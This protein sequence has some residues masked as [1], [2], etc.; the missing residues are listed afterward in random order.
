MLY[1]F[2]MITLL[3]ILSEQIVFISTISSR[4]TRR[5]DSPLFIAIYRTVK[6]NRSIIAVSTCRYWIE[7]PNNIKNIYKRAQFETVVKSYPRGDWHLFSLWFGGMAISVWAFWMDV[8]LSNI[9]RNNLGVLRWTFILKML[10]RYNFVD[11][12]FSLHSPYVSFFILND[13]LFN[14]TFIFRIWN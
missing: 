8:W 10:C 13:S 12:N 4:S 1:W 2:S 3:F 7:L 11:L 5:G 9:K 6:Y 14:C